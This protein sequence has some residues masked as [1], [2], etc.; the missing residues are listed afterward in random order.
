MAK[1]EDIFTLQMGKTPARANDDYWHNGNNPWVSIADLSTYNKYVSDTK[2]SITDIAVS[3]SGIKLVPANTVIMS[4]KLSI[5]KVAITRSPI[6]TNEAIMAFIPN[7]KSEVLPDYLYYLFLSK[8]WNDGTNRAVMGATLNKATLSELEISIPSLEEQKCIAQKLDKVTVLIALRQK[9]LEKLD[10]LVKSRFLEMFG[11]PM[12]NSKGYT[13]KKYGEVFE[14]NA[15]GTPSKS[16]PEYW[17]NGNISWIGSNMCQ[18]SVIFENDGNYITEEGLRHSSAKIFPVDTVLIALVG[19]TIGKTALLKFETT[20][21]QNV[22][23]IRGIKQNGYTPE[24]VFYYTQGLYQKFLAIGD[25][26]FAMAT[27]GFISELHIPVVPIEEQTIF[28]AFVAQTDK[29]KS[30][31]QKS[32]EQLETLKKSLMQ[33]YFG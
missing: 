9:Q 4:F 15:G 33:K 21:N 6:Y 7:G 29:S 19:A 18:N 16:Q 17:E 1:L 3:D 13:T 26:G 11:D 27:K 32:L 28:A 8:D 10:E 25:G 20:T 5:G 12:T 2:E 23:G 14:L 22:L 24:F 31:I 30:A